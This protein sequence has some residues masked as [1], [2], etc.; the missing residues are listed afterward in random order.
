MYIYKHLHAVKHKECLF[1]LTNGVPY[2]FNW[3]TSF[4]SLSLN[5][6]CSKSRL[7]WNRNYSLHG[8]TEQRK[9]EHGKGRTWWR[10]SLPTSHF[11]GFVSPRH[12]AYR[13]HLLTVLS[14]VGAAS[15]CWLVYLNAVCMHTVAVTRCH[16]FQVVLLCY[17]SWNLHSFNLFEKVTTTKHRDMVLLG[18]QWQQGEQ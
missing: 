11:L 12:S 9:K 3:K 4:S 8:A 2:L 15:H 6:S 7:P 1:Q 18:V 5:R 17:W 16:V 10:C 13:E 14:S